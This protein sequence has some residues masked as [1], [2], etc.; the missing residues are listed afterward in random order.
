MKHAVFVVDQDSLITSKTADTASDLM[1]SGLQFLNNRIRNSGFHLYDAES[2]P[3]FAR[4]SR[5]TQM[6]DA[7]QITSML[8]VHTEVDHI[9]Q[10]LNMT[11]RLHVSA[12]DAE[13]EV[14]LVV[15]GHH[16]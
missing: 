13:A 16:G 5:A 7:S 8:H 15:L 12:H 4:R 14:R 3:L 2:I 10:D 11:L 9:N 6:S 1:A